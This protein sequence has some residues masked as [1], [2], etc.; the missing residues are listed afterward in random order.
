[1]HNSSLSQ[2]D[3]LIRDNLH[4]HMD[5]YPSLKETYSPSSYLHDSAYDHTNIKSQQSNLQGS[6]ERRDSQL[7]GPD[8]QITSSLENIPTSHPGSQTR[9]VQPFLE[10]V[11]E[12]SIEHS[13]TNFKVSMVESDL[14]RGKYDYYNLHTQLG[15]R[16]LPTSTSHHHQSTVLDNKYDTKYK[17]IGNT[18]DIRSHESERNFIS[19]RFQLENVESKRSKSKDSARPQEPSAR[20]KFRELSYDEYTS[21]KYSE[22]SRQGFDRKR[23]DEY[24]RPERKQE[25]FERPKTHKERL[26]IERPK[27]FGQ[28]LQ[29][30]DGFD[31]KGVEDNLFSISKNSHYGPSGASSVNS[32]VRKAQQTSTKF[33]SGVNQSDYEIDIS[34][35][36]AEKKSGYADVPMFSKTESSFYKKDSTELLEMLNFERSKNEKLEERLLYREQLLKQMKEFHDELYQNYIELKNEL[37]KTK[38]EKENI[39]NE[40]T[41]NH[42]QNE[43]LRSKI[44]QLEDQVYELRQNENKKRAIIETL[45]NENESLKSELSVLS[46]KYEARIDALNSRVEKLK[47]EKEELNAD[48]RSMEQRLEAVSRKRDVEDDQEKML[49]KASLEESNIQIRTLTHQN[50]ELLHRL[51]TLKRLHE[52]KDR[53]YL[54]KLD[55]SYQENTRLIEEKVNQ[56]RAELHE[57]NKDK[58]ALYKQKIAKLEAENDDLRMQL[59]SKVEELKSQTREM[60]KNSS[61][62]FGG[63][64]KRLLRDLADELEVQNMNEILPRLK[65]ILHESKSNTKFVDKVTELV[66]SCSPPG[67]FKSRPTVKQAWKWIRRLMEEYM[68]MK[69]GTTDSSREILRTIMDYLN[70]EEKGEAISK[71]KQLLSENSLMNKI[72]K[73]IKVIHNLDWVTSLI[74]L[75]RKLESELDTKYDD[76]YHKLKYYKLNN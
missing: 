59:G 27:S 64:T 65:E 43:L 52:E 21:K 74:E 6:Q 22:S 54:M 48:L 56:I 16:T 63:V 72:I 5:K 55:S 9:G 76:P 62:G 25:G 66:A 47:R 58:I 12:R 33:A 42:N 7:S 36:Y 32:T 51:E 8:I 68:S 73:K 20:E 57:K 15:H 26:D 34:E 53:N 3:S 14:S 70:V 19:P 69:K 29:S 23:L 10:A 45:E 44:N 31:K 61:D 67:H 11:P 49:L 40:N 50:E 13:D 35:K 37:D 38:I 60:R 28:T 39:Y 1:M 75:D 18:F 24:E 4:S 17:T 46:K 41:L 71:V 2:D 30:I